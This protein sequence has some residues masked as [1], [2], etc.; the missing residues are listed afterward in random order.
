[1]FSFKLSSGHIE[2]SELY[3]DN[4]MWTGKFENRCQLKVNF[5]TTKADGWR[6]FERKR[7][8]GLTLLVRE[9]FPFQIAKLTA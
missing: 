4:L 2:I 5:I 7:L 1:M 6:A 3:V 8:S 9:V